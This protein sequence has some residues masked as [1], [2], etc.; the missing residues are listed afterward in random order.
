MS[1]FLGTGLHPGKHPGKHPGQHPGKHP[2]KGNEP[3]ATGPDATLAAAMAAM[4]PRLQRR[5]EETVM[6]TP[7]AGPG[8]EADAGRARTLLRWDPA[9][10]VETCAGEVAAGLWVEDRVLKHAPRRAG[11]ATVS[12]LTLSAPAVL[13]GGDVSPV[14]QVQAVAVVRAAVERD[15]R[16]AEILSQTDDL[17]PFW[18]AVT[19]IDPWRC[20]RTREVVA[21]AQS[22]GE[23]VV[24]QF[25]HQIALVR[26]WQVSAHVAPVIPTPGHGSL[27]S[28]HATQAFMGAVVLAR[29][30]GLADDDPTTKLLRRLAQRIAHNRVVA[31]VHYPMDSVAGYLLGDVLGQHLAAVGTHTRSERVGAV[32]DAGSITDPLLMQLEPADADLLPAGLPVAPGAPGAAPAG[33]TSCPDFQTLWALARHELAARQAWA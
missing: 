3:D 12:L 25:K 9:V 32:F 2:G 33:P 5:G 1:L 21:V 24:M 10:R 26:P 30:L 15:D 20:P 23:R 4:R 17:W 19:G 13:D 11:A 7:P 29:L 27:P 18:A 31:G 6:R 22:V 28:G 16:M 14:L 8:A